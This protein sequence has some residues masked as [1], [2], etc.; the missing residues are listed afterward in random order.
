MKQKSRYSEPQQLGGK[1]IGLSWLDRLSELSLQNARPIDWHA[2]AELEIVCCIKGRL[3]YE[4]RNRP[5][6]TLTA[7]CFLV[8]PGGFDHRLADGVDSPGR[9]ISFFVRTNCPPGSRRMPFS[10]TEYRDLLS[11]ILKKRCRP[12][13]FPPSFRPI[14]TRIA[15]LVHTNTPTPSDLIELR[16]LTAAA[17]VAFAQ[18]RVT[19]S[20]KSPARL[21]DESIRWLRAHWQEKVSLEQMATFMG[22]SQTRFCELFKAYTG[23]PPMEWLI[24]YRME[25]ACAILKSEDCTISAAARRVGFPDPLFFS[26]IFRKR[27]GV[28]PREYQRKFR[29]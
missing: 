9:R 20:P 24:R 17:L 3:R 29:S 23:L 2:H 22:Y 14:M 1:S 13:A 4:F 25:N 10:P 19:K 26:R 27:I 15:D 6:A 11:D 18:S 8:I 7:D 5:N 21:I 16:T 28:T 12:N